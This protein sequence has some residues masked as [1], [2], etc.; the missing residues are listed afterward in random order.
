[1]S[2]EPPEADDAAPDT[3][4]DV[5]EPRLWKKD[6]W[7]A[8]VVVN[9]DDEG[10]AVEMS[11]A[12]DPEPALVGHWTMGR[13]KKNPKPMDQAAFMTLIKTATEVQ[14]R[15]KQSERERLHKSL[16]FATDAGQR[17]R[18][19]FDIQP[20]D[21][22]PHAILAVFDEATDEPIRSGRVGAG[23]KLTAS[24]VQTFLRTGAG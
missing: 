16:A 24:T 13:D 6:G 22:D 12:G 21:D 9:E 14:L 2:N 11:R 1:M 20:D 7:V 15:H 19:A 10:W 4:A 23:F 3:S 8:R 5:L 17:V 18:V